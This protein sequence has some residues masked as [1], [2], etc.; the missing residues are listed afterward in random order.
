MTREQPVTAVENALHRRWR[1]LLPVYVILAVIALI[2]IIGTILGLVLLWQVAQN[3]TPRYADIVEEFK[4]G[5]I[6][7]EP[8][9]GI[10][11]RIWRALPGLFPEAF[12]GR[13]DYSAFGFLYEKDANGEQRELPI[14]IARRVVRGVEVVW[15]NC[16]TCHTGTVTTADPN[17]PQ[18]T[19]RHIVPGM[20][21]NNLDLYRFIRFLLDAGADERLSADRLIPAMN[22]TGKKLGWIEEII[23]RWYVI[24]TL[25]EG[26]IQRRSRLLPLLAQQPAWGPGRVDTFNPYKLLQANIPIGS[27]DPKELV[28]TADFPSIFYQ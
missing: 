15:F 27:L 9:S 11:R 20:P 19:V 4:Y 2:G 16:A 23:Y 14:G 5:S 8:H 3:R 26:L 13:N 18:R 22:A 10:P 7:A 12:Q 28:G 24:P 6:G 1:L 25:R 21:S 17:D